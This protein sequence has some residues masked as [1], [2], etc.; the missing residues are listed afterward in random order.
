MNW[1]EGRIDWAKARTG[2]LSW[3]SPRARKRIAWTGGTIGAVLVALVLFLGFLD[4]N[5]LKRPVENLLSARTGRAVHIDGNLSVRLL[6]WTPGA[7]VEGLRV[8][9][10]AWAGG[11][12]TFNIPKLT[13]KVKLLPLLKGDVILPLLQIDRPVISLV[14][15]AD[16]QDNWTFGKRSNKPFGLPPIRRFEINQ[17]QVTLKDGIRKLNFAGTV[18]S[19]E[20]VEGSNVKAFKLRGDGTLNAAPFD[21]DLTGGPL[22]NVDPGKPYPFDLKLKAGDSAAHAEGAL[23]KPFNLGVID[24]SLAISGQDLANLYELTGLTLPNSPPYHLTGRF[25]RRDMVYAYDSLAGVIGSSDLQGA[26]AVR[27]GGVRP[28]LTGDLHSRKLD[29]GDLAAVLGGGAAQT[30]GPKA[31]PEQAQRARSLAARNEIF[32]DTPL[33]TE[34]LRTMDAHVKY[35][36]DAIQS[37]GMHMRSGSAELTL[38]NGLL[39]LNPLQFD[40]PNGR[41]AGSLVIDARNDVPLVQADLRLSGA[42]IDEFIPVAY[43]GAA[44]GALLGRVRL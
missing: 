19:S 38:Q 22:L 8:G 14:R 34:R 6:S 28:M 25:T 35:D 10:P 31:S 5:L 16:G 36:A 42:R 33:H 32:P 17:G 11:G 24:A 41:I 27:I 20:V 4:W 21:L 12:D 26:I 15:Q 29:L 39:T 37:T 13:V 18:N 23:A 44:S 7:T 3:P 43:K 2:A 40:L 30:S 9:N 1:L